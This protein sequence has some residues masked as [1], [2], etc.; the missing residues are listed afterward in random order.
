MVALSLRCCIVAIVGFAALSSAPIIRSQTPSGP[1]RIAGVAVSLTNGAPLTSARVTIIDTKNP[2]NAKWV[3][4]HEDGHFEFD[5]LSAGK[6]SLQGAH[7]GFIP[8]AYEQHGQFSTAIVTGAGLDTENLI[9]RLQ[10]DATISGK[11]LD[12]SGE[13]VRE[14]NVRLYRANHGLGVSQIMGFGAT[15]TDDQGSYEFP[16][17]I[18]GVYF[19]SA[20][21]TPW[22]A[23]HG[24]SQALSTQAV[25]AVDPSLD[26]C[27]P[28]TY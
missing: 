20:A 24:P 22:Y 6:Y 13:P 3:I 8:T 1:F 12:E 17:L 14:A 15:S 28:T 11:V 26:V 16:E 23:I 27:Y 2:R 5:A 9:L 18:P 19:V 21:A 7:R 4:T 10:P 25:V